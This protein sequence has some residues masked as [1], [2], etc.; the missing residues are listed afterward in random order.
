MHRACDLSRTEP[1][2]SSAVYEIN[3]KRTVSTQTHATMKR[4]VKKGYLRLRVW[5]REARTRP[6]SEIHLCLQLASSRS[7]SVLFLLCVLFCPGCAT[8]VADAM[9][10]T[11]TFVIFIFLSSAPVARQ[12]TPAARSQENIRNN[13]NKRFSLL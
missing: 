3:V 12:Q 7:V 13:N 10:R 1:K 8:E 4:S 11:R 6:P 5:W 9:T 2:V